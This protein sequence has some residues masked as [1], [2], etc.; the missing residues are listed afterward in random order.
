M[1][2]SASKR[3]RLGRQSRAPLCL[4]TN[5]VSLLPIAGAAPLVILIAGATGPARFVWRLGLACGAFWFLSV[6]APS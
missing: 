3:E 2:A 4:E 6:S 5:S 1:R